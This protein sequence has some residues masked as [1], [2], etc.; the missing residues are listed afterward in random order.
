MK[1]VAPKGVP[2]N[3]K[4]FLRALSRRLLR[5]TIQSSEARVS[6]LDPPH[7]QTED[8][9]ADA[10][11]VVLKPRAPRPV[12]P[13]PPP[14][15][16][17]A[18]AVVSFDRR[19]LQTILNLYGRKVAEGEWKDYAIAF[20]R[21][22]AIFSVFRRAAEVPLYRIEKSPKLAR[23]QGAYS[24][25]SAT[26]LILKRGQDLARVIAVLEKKLKLVTA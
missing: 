20:T 10:A 9:G 21:E 11:L 6:E 19:E 4:R 22:T 2:H 16:P 8:D 23:K 5:A 13:T 26:G 12:A 25:V 3:A 24:V 17:A 7:S 14:Q 1:R 18:P 15:Q